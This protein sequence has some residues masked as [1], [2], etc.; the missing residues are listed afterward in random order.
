MDL[1][2]LFPI[3]SNYLWFPVAFPNTHLVLAYFPRV[4]VLLSKASMV[5]L[6]GDRVPPAM[7]L[8]PCQTAS[9]VVFDLPVRSSCDLGLLAMLLVQRQIVSAGAFGLQAHSLAVESC[10]IACP[11]LIS[12]WSHLQLQRKA[13]PEL[14]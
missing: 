1:V 9:S 5:F 6:S 7:L 14:P 10:P 12:A 8:V 3:G 13:V 4:Q 11:G 2:L